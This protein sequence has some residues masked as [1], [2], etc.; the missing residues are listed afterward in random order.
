M[1]VIKR[2]F[3]FLLINIVVVTTIST[4]ISL[5]HLSPYISRFGIDPTSLLIFCF[6]WGMGGSIISLLLSKKIAKWTM[7][8]KIISPRSEIKEEIELMKIVDEL[9]SKSN[10]KKFSKLGFL[11]NVSPEIGIY[12]SPEVNAFATGATKKNSLIALSTGL[13][14]KMEKEEIKAVLAHEI[15]HI[16]NGDMVTMTLLQ[17]IINTFVMFLSRILAFALSISSKD[18][19]NR[20]NFSYLGYHLFT[21]LFQTIFMI[22]GTLGI[23]AF[24]RK[25]EFKA[26][27]G[28][29]ML[30]GKEKMIIAL[31]RLRSLDKT[32]DPLF[33]NQTAAFNTLKISNGASNFFK[34][35][36]T[37]PPLEDRID[38]LKNSFIP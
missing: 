16:I 8:I 9:L 31:E 34:L 25:R 4:I 20:N 29:A 11:K 24:S 2:V 5:L 17:G 14:S 7:G 10:L 33:Q 22:F 28:G 36:S 38:R 35:F 23:C 21:M 18:K 32:K 30:A 26:D 6:I 13:L 15:S 3:L 37:H 1:N 27:F 12:H 19:D